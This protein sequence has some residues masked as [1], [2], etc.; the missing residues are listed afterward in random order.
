MSDGT[1][2]PR[3]PARPGPPGLDLERLRDHLDRERPGTVRGPL[4]A[5]L[6]EGGRSNLTYR[7]TDGTGQWVV[8][9][10]PLG[11]V[12]AT[13]HDMRREFRVI[14]ALHPTAVPVPGTLLL[15][16]DEA[17]L[18]AP[19]YV[20]ELVAGTPYR[21][22]GQLA[23]LGPERTR[24][25]VLSLVDTLVALHAVD[26]AAVGL[27]DFGRPDG[28]LERQLR[29]WGKQLAASRSRDLPGIDALHEALAG[30]LPASPAPTVVH[31]D[32][33]LD[34]VLVGADDR[35][36]A[37]LDWEMST[38][39]DPLTDLGLLVMYSEQEDVPGS[40]IATTRGAPGHPEPAELI[41][42]YAAGSGRDVSGIAWYTAFAYFK[43]AVILEGIHYR[44]T[45]G[46]TVGAGFDR[47]G[48]LVPVF[49]DRGRATLDTL[50]TTAEEG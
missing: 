16:E 36:T 27:D 47:I 12:L 23:E 17:V 18:G 39:G 50:T 21:T 10:P 4:K 30:S 11:H 14:S 20:M 3:S 32:Y 42:R 25:V 29:R 49:I 44:Y 6:I 2:P 5:E 37:V 31:G 19:F 1:P 15:C 8:R 33:R 28:F 22:A 43:L 34:N 48:E 41:E 26:P 45:L 35:I 7:I 40:P 13:A 24:G 38:L 46:Q 9:R